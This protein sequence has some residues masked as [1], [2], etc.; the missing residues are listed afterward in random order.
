MEKKWKALEV[1]DPKDKIIFCG[2][3][4]VWSEVSKANMSFY[5]VSK[6]P[7]LR[8]DDFIK[9]EEMNPQAPCTFFK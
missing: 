8:V 2:K 9:V 3:Y 1:K 7:L 5:R 6:I 4:L